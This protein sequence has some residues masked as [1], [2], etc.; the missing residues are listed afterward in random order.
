[1]LGALISAVFAVACGCAAQGLLH[2][3]MK[4]LD[5]G[6]R[7]GLGG[8]IGLGAFGTLSVFV[9]LLPNGVAWGLPALAGVAVVGAIAAWQGKKL[10]SP[11]VQIPKGWAILSPVYAVLIGLLG[12]V[13]ALAPST[14]MDWDSLAYHLAA[15]KIWLLDGQVGPIQA[16]H[17]SN[18]PFAIDGLYLYG[19]WWGGEAGAKAF[20]VIIFGAGAL[21]LFGHLRR[22]VGASAAWWAVPAFASIPVVAWESGTAYVDVGHGLFAAFALLYGSEAMT[23]KRAGCWALA[24][25]CLGFCLGSKHT[26]LHIGLAF[27][28]ASLVV[29][30]LR[31]DFSTLKG[32]G[33]AA[34]LG[35]S[36]AA[37]WYAK[38]YAFTGNP[39]FPF[40]HS[41]FQSPEWDDWRA[42]IY[43]NEQQTFGVGRTEEGR[44]FLQIGHAV[45]G[46]AYQPGRYVNPGQTQGLGF[47]TGAVGAAAV[48]LA[49]IPAAMGWVNRR[50]Q[51][52]LGAMGLGMIL[53]FILSQQSRYLTIWAIPACAVG[54]VALGLLDK[55]SLRRPL[56]GLIALQA[57]Y[58]LY[59]IHATTTS[60]QI[61]V[62]MGGM[63][64]S[65]YRR[66]TTSFA[67]A[68]EEINTRE[69]IKR[70]A[71]Y[72]EVFGFLLDK[73]YLWANP[74]HSR[75]IPYETLEDGEMYADAMLELGFS[76]AYIS[77]AFTAPVDLERWLAA[78]GVQ[79][80]QPYQG[81]DRQAQMQNLDLKW[82]VLIAEAVRSGRAVLEPS[83]GRGL[84]LRFTPRAG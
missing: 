22:T 73:P 26:G 14:T 9:G 56:Q 44:D 29:M 23:T 43:A 34:G 21:A 17:H 33:L 57:A 30:A 82:R 69:D 53:W 47:P 70:I 80:D 58:T 2:R 49:L 81:E 50:S 28:A 11:S 38:S 83:A 51:L 12:L 68:A 4:E 59:L 6:E 39:V 42:E 74:G 8:L 32:L 37:P 36:L 66:Q 55:A 18:F 72:D 45:L 64:A 84:I 5:P 35:L 77:T 41:V 75:V 40:L 3:W 25:I 78:M 20:S 13:G 1:M 24:G 16:M 52:L 27:G 54:A 63:P 62:V 46:L 7:W 71:L 10:P 19:L 76:H 67:V 65:E 79:G 61:A 60:S 31:R 15:P 48:L